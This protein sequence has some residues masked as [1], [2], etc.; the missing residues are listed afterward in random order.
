MPTLMLSPISPLCFRAY[1]TKQ[2]IVYFLPNLAEI[3]LNTCLDAV[4]VVG[5]N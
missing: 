1:V 3:S 4:N 5:V 2:S